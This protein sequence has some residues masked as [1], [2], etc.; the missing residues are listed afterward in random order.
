[1]VRNHR[2]LQ[3]LLSCLNGQRGL[4]NSFALD[5]FVKM[6]LPFLLLILAIHKKWLLKIARNVGPA[7]P[8]C[9]LAKQVLSVLLNRSEAV[10][11]YTTNAI[12]G[13]AGGTHVVGVAVD[14][15]WLVLLVGEK[16]RGVAD[17]DGSLLLVASQ[18]LG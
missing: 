8:D 1:M 10:Q 12:I 11:L 16:L 15:K 13:A 3:V 9:C 2:A 7:P 4:K 5:F 18:H 14:D 6:L 17:V